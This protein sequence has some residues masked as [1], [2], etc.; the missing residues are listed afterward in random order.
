MK[1]SFILGRFKYVLIKV[2]AEELPDGTEPSKLVV[3]GN[4][5]AEWH[6]NSNFLLRLLLDYYLPYYLEKFC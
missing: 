1:L 2:Y 4:V 3:R 6:G 5:D